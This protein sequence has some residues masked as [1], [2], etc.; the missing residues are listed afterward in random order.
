MS[1]P[2]QLGD[3]PGVGVRVRV[4]VKIR[5]RVKVKVRVRVRVKVNPNPNLVSGRAAS[6]AMLSGGSYA[7]ARAACS[8]ASSGA[9]PG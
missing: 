4:R 8:Y 5:V 9:A 1:P 6:H 7:P 2:E 3:R